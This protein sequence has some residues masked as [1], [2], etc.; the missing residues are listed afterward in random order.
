M[1]K[2]KLTQ[3][4][5]NAIERFKS[6]PKADLVKQHVMWK[7]KSA[8]KSLN[9]LTI[10]E[11]IRAL[12]I[13][14]EVEPKF[15]VGDWVYYQGQYEAERVGKI[16]H[17]GNDYIRYDIGYSNNKKYFRHA[18]SEEIAKEKERRWWKSHDRNV[19]EL[20]KGD[21]IIDKLNAHSC[22]VKIVE[23]VDENGFNLLVDGLSHFP[24]SL[25]SIKENYKILCFAEDRK[26]V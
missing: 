8:G 16:T 21:L 26:D 9:D 18:T 19:W 15:K 22:A 6:E 17:I 11:L 1:G 7:W 20:K 24:I 14:Y 23:H 25:E 3:E 2:V 4:Q 10:D 12:Y 13:G 5:A